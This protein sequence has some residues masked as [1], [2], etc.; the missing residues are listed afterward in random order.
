MLFNLPWCFVLYK[1]SS[2]LDDLLELLCSDAIM[3]DRLDDAEK[4]LS[5]LEQKVEGINPAGL[6]LFFI[7]GNLS[8]RARQQIPAIFFHSQSLLGLF[9][10]ARISAFLLSASILLIGLSAY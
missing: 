3:T 10:A 4:M 7:K 5:T 2:L 6:L 8:A 1:F 9:F